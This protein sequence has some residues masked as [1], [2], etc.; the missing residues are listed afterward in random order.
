MSETLAL[1]SSRWMA[2]A[3]AL[4]RSAVAVFAP[5][6]ESSEPQA[7]TSAPGRASASSTRSSRVVVIG[8]GGPG[9]GRRGAPILPAAP[10]R[11][12]GVR[13]RRRAARR[14]ARRPRARRR[15]ARSAAGSSP[16]AV[17]VSQSAN[18]AFL[19]SSGPWRYVPSTVPWRAAADALEAAG[20][21]VAVALEHAAERRGARSEPRAAAVVLEAREHAGPAGS[22]VDLDRDVADQPR[23]VLAHGLEV[24]EADA[25]AGARRRTRSRGRA[26]GSRR[27]RRTGPRRAPRRRAARRA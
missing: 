8:R 18:Q 24:D 1:A 14:R 5:S 19:G 15:A 13:P 23:A 17:A 4:G 27:R 22:Q 11:P 25:R 10:G 16:S 6:E 7:D 26:A 9:T 12:S 3:A 2:V 21:V 20:A